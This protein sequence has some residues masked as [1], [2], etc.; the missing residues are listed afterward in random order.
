MDDWTWQSF[1]TEQIGEILALAPYL[2]HPPQKENIAQKIEQ[3]ILLFSR[4]SAK[5]FA[6]LM[7]LSPSVPLDWRHGRALPVLNL[8]LRVC[9]RLSIPLLD[10]LTG[11][12]TIKQLQ[13]LKDL[14]ICQQYRKTN[15]PFDISQVQ[16]L[17]ETALL[18]EP[19]LSVRQVAKNIKYDI[20]DLYRHF[21]DLCHKITAR[22]KLYKK[23]NSI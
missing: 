4:G 14:P 22:Y 15:R 11:N 3:C 19:P 10:F 18:A 7:Y 13:P 21:P 12:I 6:D 17:L 23:S 1:V 16:K 9:Y 5:A 2:M 20:T 8:L